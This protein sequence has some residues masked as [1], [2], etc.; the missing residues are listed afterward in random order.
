VLRWVRNSWDAEDITQ[1]I[2]LELWKCADRY[3]PKAGSEQVFVSTIA[4]RRL[5]DRLRSQ[6][7]RPTTEEYDEER[8]RDDSDRDPD[9]AA[10]AFDVELATQAI[11]QLGE[12]QREILTMGVVAGMTHSEIAEAT[13]KPL[14]TVKTQIRRGLI[15]VRDLMG[16][17][18]PSEAVQ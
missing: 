12:G 14:G 18:T 1:E 13:G 10:V 11:E 5:I 16:S 6:G 2:F 8:Q 9:F 4:R 17:A 7:R 15:K 3:N